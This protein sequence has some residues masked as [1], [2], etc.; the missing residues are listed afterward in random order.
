MDKLPHAANC[1]NRADLV[2]FSRGQLPEPALET[3]A[4]HIAGCPACETSMGELLAEDTFGALPAVGAKPHFIDESACHRLEATAKAFSLVADE[5]T[6][7]PEMPH[8]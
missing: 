2:A 4:N 7:L 1:P 3:I 5:S 8:E 6:T